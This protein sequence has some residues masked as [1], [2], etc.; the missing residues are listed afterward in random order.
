MHA[1]IFS[2]GHPGGGVR[3]RSEA[4]AMAAYGEQLLPRREGEEEGKARPQPSSWLLEEDSTS[5][6]TNAVFSLR[7]AAARGWRGVAV[8][9]NPFHQLRALLT[10][11]C[12]AQQ[13]AAVSGTP[14]LEV[15]LARVPPETAGRGYA[16]R[17]GRALG[18]LWMNYD[19]AREVAALA[20]YWLRGWLC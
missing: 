9:T 18:A 16:G 2:G 4:A 20:W 19:I 8:A 15:V 13:Q 12:A 3:V 7:I 10:F 1:I 5:T 6:R 14:P 11:R 17:A